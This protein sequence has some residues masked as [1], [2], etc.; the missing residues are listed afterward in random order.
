MKKAER[1]PLIVKILLYQIIF[2]VVHYLYDWFPNGV[3]YL[4]GATSESVF[5]HM[6]AVFYAYLLLTTFEYVLFRAAIRSKVNYLYGRMFCASIMPLLMMTYFLT[7][8]AFFVKIESIPLEIL[9]ANIALIAVSFSTFMLV[10]YFEES[11]P[12]RGLKAVIIVLFALT[13]IELV[14]F[15]YRLPWFDIFAIPPGW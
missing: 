11:E 4:F 8:P 13:L 3:T 6:K 7:G 12:A 9:F 1:F 10:G 5:Q 2:L 15:S 14:I